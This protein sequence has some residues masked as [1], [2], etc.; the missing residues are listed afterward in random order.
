MLK[1]HGLS[2]NRSGQLNEFFIL[3]RIGQ[4]VGSYVQISSKTY[5]R[6]FGLRGDPSF[7]VWFA[8]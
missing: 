7:T 4:H 8:F 5:A 6:F 2:A 1:H 3:E